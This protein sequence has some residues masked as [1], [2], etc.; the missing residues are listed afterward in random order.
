MNV[1]KV[2]SIVVFIVAAVYLLRL[3]SKKVGG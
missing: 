3:A 2:L 1:T